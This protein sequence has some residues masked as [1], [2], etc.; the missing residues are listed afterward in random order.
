[1]K[2]TIVFL[3]LYLAAV[4]L[5]AQP[6]KKTVAADGSGDY[7]TV[8]EAFDAVPLKSKKAFIIYIKAGTYR[9]KLHLDSS[10]QFVTI[11]GEDKFRTILTWDDHTGKLSPT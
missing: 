2:S 8:Q 3:F 6:V 4:C 7:K 10:K 5:S 11:I 9:E 1:M